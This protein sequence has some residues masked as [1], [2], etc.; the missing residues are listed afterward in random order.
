MVEFPSYATILIDGYNEEADFGV[1][2]TDMDSGIGKQRPRFSMP[3]IT[4]N[5][6]IMVCSDTHKERFDDWFDDD[7]NGG[8]GWF[9]LLLPRPERIVQARI[10]DGKFTWSAPQLQSWTGTCKLETLGR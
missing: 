5:V 6:T 10:I 2:R 7:L 9:K 4:R 8:T 1:L 3:I